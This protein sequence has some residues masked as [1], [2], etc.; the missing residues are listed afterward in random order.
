MLYIINVNILYLTCTVP[1]LSFDS[2]CIHVAVISVFIS[3]LRIHDILLWIRIRGS[4]PL[5][6]GSG[7]GSKRP[8]TL[9]IRR[10]GLGSGSETLVYLYKTVLA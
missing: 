8:K 7:S 9:R 5:E 3:V 6:N 4:I 10:T 2:Q 1:D